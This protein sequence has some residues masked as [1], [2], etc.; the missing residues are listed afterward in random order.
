[1]NMYRRQTKKTDLIEACIWVGQDQVFVEIF[2]VLL[3]YIWIQV[4][5]KDKVCCLKHFG[6][7]AEAYQKEES[8]VRKHFFL[9][10]AS[11]SVKKALF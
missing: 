11:E 4:K 7:Y 6:E 9:S 2:G 3:T 5:G 1:M 10:P 8:L